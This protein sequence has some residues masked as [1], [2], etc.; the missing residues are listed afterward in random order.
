MAALLW[1]VIPVAA[2]LLA[3]VWAGWAARPRTPA[4]TID[5]VKTYERFRTT[6]EDIRRT[7]EESR[8]VLLQSLLE[9]RSTKNGATRRRP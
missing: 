3:L 2:T 1:L 7:R 8:R 5:S 4:R 9:Q 6:I